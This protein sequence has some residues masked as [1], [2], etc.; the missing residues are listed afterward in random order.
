[1]TDTHAPDIPPPG[2]P[3]AQPA[4]AATRAC[5]HAARRWLP[6]TDTR[7]FDD[8][9]RGH[10]A[11]LPPGA[12][13]RANGGPVWNLAA[14][15][16]LAEEDAPDSVHPGLW[17]HA[18]VN[19]VTGLFQVVDR[20]WQ[21][22]GM[23]IANMTIIEG[24]TGLIVI[25]PLIST[26][27]A[28]AGMALYFQH[29]PKKPVVAMVYSHSHVDH[30]G[31]VRGVIDEA[32]VR[33]G[34]VQVIAPAGFMDEAVSENLLA[35]NAMSR[36]AL[37]QFG[38]LLPK[39][40]RGQVDAGLGK[41]TST[42]TVTLIAP[43][44][45]ISQPVERHVIDGVDCIFALTPGAEAPAELI[46]HHPGL[47]VLNMTEISSQ[48]FHNLLPLR[49][50]QVR[51][52]LAWSRYLDGALQRYGADSDVLIAQH[53]WPV[54]GGEAI[55]GFLRRQRDLYR[56]VHD[57]TLRLMN[58]GLLAAEIAERLQLP[59]ALL[60]DWACH[61]FY[62][63][64]KHNVKAIVQRYLG[65]YDGNPAH[66]DPLPPA[67]AAR[68]TLQY[69][70][71]ADAVLQRAR[72]DFDAGEYRWVAQVCAMV[73][74]AGAE[75]DASVLHAQALGADALEQLG[76]Q[77][78][79]ATW[80]NA[81]LQ[82]VMELRHGVPKLPP[83]SVA[84]RDI[85]RALPLGLYFDMLAMRLDGAKA[86]GLHLRLNWRI[87]DT[88]DCAVLNL[89]HSALTHRL[90]VQ[91]ADVHASV[92][93]DR[94]TLDDIALQKLPLADA[95]QAG[96]VQVQGDASALLRLMAMLDHFSRMFPVVG[97]RP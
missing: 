27:V 83:T 91:A 65:A 31:G 63:T 2:P 67:D 96:R 33:A 69:M 20:V 4:T 85:V 9:R 39:G 21:V 72:A 52:A 37:F 75:G 8:A 62:G 53:H 73:C 38:P 46:I 54:W 28:A 1:M 58:H 76:Y 55:D 23:D 61:G 47:R 10:V 32:D 88:G 77:A 74:H 6:L 60:D 13:T 51:D 78:E 17:R 81:Y 90:G 14:Y 41:T 95:L 7:S 84:V 44:V 30:F 93:M 26:E 97:T 70:G 22:R 40:V 86:D 42:G 59:Q 45:V 92:A 19:M 79:S 34:R 43:T 35:G 82:A 3:G 68:K 49:G 29:R 87:T 80:R 11:D 94:A 15:G 24:D 71:G 50:A 18:R 57:Q 12:I 56:Y 64:V 16:F 25:D 89:E 48:N 5:Q 36:R 66:L